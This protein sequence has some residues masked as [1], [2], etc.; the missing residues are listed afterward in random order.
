[1]EN[2]LESFTGEFE[3]QTTGI[4]EITY[5]NKVKVRTDIFNLQGRRLNAEP[6]HGVYIKNGKKVVK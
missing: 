4:E 6:K 2:S 3:V 1:M 5:N